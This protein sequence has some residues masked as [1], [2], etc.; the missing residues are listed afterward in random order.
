MGKARDLVLVLVYAQGMAFVGKA[1]KDAI[2]DKR[3]FNL[4]DA[5]LFITSVDAERGVLRS[6]ITGIGISTGPHKE[7]TINDGIVDV[8]TPHNWGE[9]EYR[10][11]AEDYEIFCHGEA[12]SD[13]EPMIQ[14]V[15]PRAVPHI[16][17]R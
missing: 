13:G 14:S 15:D 10:R 17:G 2:R 12:A 8:V 16:L 1:Y 9:K 7:I 11:M 5:G 4:F 3:R 6:A